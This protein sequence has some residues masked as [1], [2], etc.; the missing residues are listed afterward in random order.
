MAEA[1]GNRSLLHPD[2]IRLAFEAAAQGGGIL[3][4]R[5]PERCEPAGCVVCEWL[6]GEPS[7][8]WHATL[9]Q[10]H[11]AFVRLERPSGAA[12][13]RAAGR[14]RKR[15]AEAG[16]AAS[17]TD[18][19]IGF[20]LLELPAG[21]SKED[22]ES[23]LLRAVRE[24]MTSAE[25]QW[26]ERGFRQEAASEDGSEA[27]IGSLAAPLPVFGPAEPVSTAALLFERNPAV[28]AVVICDHGRQIGLI[29]KESL[30]R[31]LSGQFGLSLYWNRP[32]AKIMDADPLI[33]EANTAVETVSRMAMA[34][35]IDKLYD[36]VIV[37]RDGRLAGAASIRSILECVTKLRM[38]AA[39]SA[40]PLTGLPG[41]VGIRR[42]L[43]RRIEAGRP[44]A[45][46][47]ADLDYF[48]WFND[49]FGFRKGDDMIRYTAEVLQHV[50]Q[51]AGKPGDFVG[52]IGG[53]DFI[54]MTE[55]DDPEAVCRQII[56]RFDDGA[57]AFHDT[58]IMPVTDREGQAV[59]AKGVSISLAI[60]SWNGAVP[61]HP[62]MFAELA[63]KLKKQVKNMRGSAYIHKQLGVEVE[64]E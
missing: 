18:A 20:A 13:E 33:V 46:L 10:D 44:F 58:G 19:A 5:L 49:C 36:M 55:A 22:V 60:A 32:V 38:E 21:G 7:I 9:G 59:D 37:T 35:E 29:G 11:A 48:K 3:V 4:V 52:H 51:H 26:A 45:V 15:F 1:N 8:V 28:Q 12:L 24:A 2:F 61:A 6:A 63:A 41:N 53:D 14:L 27:V 42:E 30:H 62:D 34:R 47:Y 25:R 54:V 31:L 16:T 17:E 43:A 23:A 57:S 64:D 39:R 50:V 40:N 56:R